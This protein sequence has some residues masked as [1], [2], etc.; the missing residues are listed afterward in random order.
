MVLLHKLLWSILLVKSYSKSP[1]HA[2]RMLKKISREMTSLV[3]VFLYVESHEK[4]TNRRRH[5]KV[6]DH[7]TFDKLVMLD[8][9]PWIYQ[10]FCWWLTE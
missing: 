5:Y 9:A 10:Q 8:L 7:V 3:Q 6:K 2:A 1:Y 4:L